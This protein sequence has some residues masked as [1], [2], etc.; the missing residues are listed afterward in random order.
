MKLRWTFLGLGAACAACCAPLILPLLGGIGVLGVTGAMAAWASK[1]TLDQVLCLGAPLAAFAVA[2]GWMII[3]SRRKNAQTCDCP[4]AC[5]AQT[6]SPA[7][8]EI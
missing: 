6:C 4:Q 7:G 1:V 5:D 8:R 3:K 2:G